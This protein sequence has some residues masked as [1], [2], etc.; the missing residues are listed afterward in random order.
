MPYPSGL[1][2]SR[3]LASGCRVVV[4]AV[5]EEIEK[6]GLTEKVRLL[7]T[8]CHGFCERGPIIVVK[9][10]DIFYSK[11]KPEWVSEIIEETVIN[12]NPIEK[13]LYK[14]P[15]IGERITTEQ[16]VPFYAVQSR[17]LLGGNVSMDPAEIEDY[18]ASG[19][20]TALVKVLFSMQ[21]EE[22]IEEVKKSGIRGRGG[23][24][25]PAGRIDQIPG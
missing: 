1:D 12:G 19:G 5:R 13:Y 3:G 2:I 9:P 25:F 17:P 8:G 16:D 4:D 15:A 6:R 20:Y 24:G 7:V 22:I 11:V 23:G 21:P 14:D 10:G 18:I